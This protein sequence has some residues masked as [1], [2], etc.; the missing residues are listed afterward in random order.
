MGTTKHNSNNSNR[1]KGFLPLRIRL[2]DSYTFVYIKEHSDDTLFATNC[3]IYPNIDPERLLFSIFGRYSDLQRVVMTGN[4]RLTSQ[5]SSSSSSNNNNESP[6]SFASVIDK[7]FAHITYQNAKEMKSSVRILSELMASSSSSSSS[8]HHEKEDELPAIVVD[9]VELQ[10]LQDQTWNHHRFTTSSSAAKRKQDEMN[11]DH[12]DKNKSKEQQQHQ[13]LEGIHAVVARYRQSLPNRDELLAAC[14]ATMEEYEAEM[15]ARS[16]QKTP[17]MDDDG[18]ITVSHGKRATRDES[19]ELEL[20]EKT[21]RR[22]TSRKTAR[23]RKKRKMEPLK[24]FYRFQTKEHR[25]KEVQELRE[26]FEQDLAKAK[27]LK[28]KPF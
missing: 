7:K 20:T 11:K 4:P 18:F 23:S 24:D 17:T 26:R 3:P 5:S 2:G 16:K 8:S 25:K 27:A 12:N 1:I 22:Q 10:T 15:A 14:N 28:E 19:M 9:P 6:T 13:Q 21:G